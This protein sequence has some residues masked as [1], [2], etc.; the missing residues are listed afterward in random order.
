MARKWPE[1]FI[2]KV[3]CGDCLEVM[4]EI[5]DNCVDL[6]VTDPPYGINLPQKSKNYGEATYC[7]RKATNLNWDKEFPNRNYW[8]E[9]FRVSKNQIV[10]GANYGWE[11]FYSTSCY[12]IWDKRADLPNVPFS[13]TE[14]AWTSFKRMPK[15]YTLINHGFIS[16]CEMTRTHPTEKPLGL[17]RAIVY[18]FTKGKPETLILDPFLGSGTTALAAKQ[19]KRRFIGIEISPDYVKIA[20]DR[21]RQEVLSF[22]NV[23]KQDKAIPSNLLEQIQKRT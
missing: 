5:P 17:I 23:Q 7:S 4:K 11:N 2:D 9:I 14:F 3:I 6:V 16:E 15:K 13:P 1:D 18:D 8:K 20:I 22:D 12:I 19:L 10:F 21:L